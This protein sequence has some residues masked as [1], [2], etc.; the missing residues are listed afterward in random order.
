MEA[1]EGDVGME[2]VLQLLDMQWPAEVYSNILEK[3][4][5]LVLLANLQDR[6][7]MGVL[8]SLGKLRP[9]MV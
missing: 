5:D 9:E 8:S 4:R 3:D 7:E 6:K 1:I 2:A